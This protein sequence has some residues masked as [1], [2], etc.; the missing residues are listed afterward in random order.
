MNEV[1]LL[2]ELVKTNSEN[3]PGNEKMMAFFV[4]DFLED[5]KISCQLMKFGENRYDLIASVGKGD[6]LMLNGH[7]DTVPVGNLENWKYDPFGKMKDGK[8]YGRG[9]VDMKGGLA[10]ILTAVRNV[11]KEKTEFKR[12]MLLAFVGDEEVAL[13]GSKFFIKNGRGFLRDVRYGVIAEPTK[14]MITR[15]QKGI[16]S[17]R[18]RIRGKAAHGSR[19]LLGDNAIYKACD[20]IQEI[21]KLIEDLKEERDDVLG[22]GTINVGKI[23]G[24]IKVNVVPD[25]CDVDIDR[26]IIP[27]ETPELARRQIEGI[28]KK[29]KIRAEVKTIL[30]RLPMKIPEDS[31]LI[32]LLKSVTKTK[33]KGESGYTEAEL[34]YRDCG[35]ECAVCG[36]GDMEL[37]HVVNEYIK[38][39]ELR[40]GVIMFEKLIK[41]WCC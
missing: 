34:Y 35:M 8:I 28:L 29:L 1:E 23:A 11:V 22:S 31:D 7:M 9:A 33:T 17:M 25:Y 21:R 6:G 16:S 26:R 36:P 19:P 38:I 40:S 27:G 39:S 37:A 2:M 14:F 32:K 15:A 24:G 30:S 41:K 12:K 20:M 3:P 4:R 18:I 5:M 10:S 13:E